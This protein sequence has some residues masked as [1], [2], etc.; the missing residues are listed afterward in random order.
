MLDVKKG[1]SISIERQGASCYNMYGV[2]LLGGVYDETY[3]VR[4]EYGG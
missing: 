1:S 4:F 2:G 3:L